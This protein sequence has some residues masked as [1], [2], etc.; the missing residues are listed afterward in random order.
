MSSK[1]L[2]ERKM[3]NEKFE[4][5]SLEE[6]NKVFYAIVRTK[7][8]N[9][10]TFINDGGYRGLK[11]SNDPIG[12]TYAYWMPSYSELEVKKSNT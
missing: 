11:A 12:V 6:T 5:P 8:N 9:E 7:A 1:N 2:T 4:A 10:D 3:F